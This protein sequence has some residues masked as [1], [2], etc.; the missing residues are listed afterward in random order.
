MKRRAD[1]ASSR[2]CSAVEPARSAKMT[3]TTL[4]VPSASAAGPGTGTGAARVAAPHS[5]QNFAAARRWA[6]QLAQARGRGAAHSSQNLAPE[7]FS[8]WQRGQVMA[9]P[10]D[11]MENREGEQRGGWVPSTVI[12][13][14]DDPPDR[15]RDPPE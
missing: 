14:V 1:S 10:Q 5:S 6:P 11:Y 8:C 4:R 2:S 15:P 7:R 9:D 13:V 3:V 12:A